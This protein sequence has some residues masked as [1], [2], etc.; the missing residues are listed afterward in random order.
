MNFG[1]KGLLV[2]PLVDVYEN[3]LKVTY[4]SVS[5]ILLAN[6]ALA[7]TEGQLPFYR[8]AISRAR[9]ATGLSG[10]RKE[11]IQAH[12]EN[13]YIQRRASEDGL[14]LPSNLDAIVETI[15]VPTTTVE[16]LFKSHDVSRVDVICIDTE[17]FDFE[18]LKLIDF[19]RY[20]P[21]I[22]I[23]ESKNLSDDDYTSAKRMLEGAGYFLYWDGG[24]TLGTREPVSPGNR[25][26]DRAH[27][28]LRDLRRRMRAR[29]SSPRPS[30]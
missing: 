3:E 10:F 16:K 26:L 17:G 21:D 13:G 2:E 27:V 22:V 1:W 14:Q 5:N 25:L 30:R 28:S 8:V 23:F 29:A 4:A 6:V 11:N 19:T 24:D 15:F 18:V 20:R 9:W 12:I 7:A